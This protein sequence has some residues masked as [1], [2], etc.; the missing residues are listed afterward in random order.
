MNS[1]MWNSCWRARIRS[2]QCALSLAEFR[3]LGLLYLCLTS[4]SHGLRRELKEFNRI[5]GPDL[6]PLVLRNISID[7][8]NEGSTIGPLTL[9]VRK[10]GGKHDPFYPNMVSRFHGHPL[11]LHTKIDVVLHILARETL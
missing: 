11:V 8:P 10:V 7:L 2:I 1:S 9:D 5:A 6:A 4:P 3:F